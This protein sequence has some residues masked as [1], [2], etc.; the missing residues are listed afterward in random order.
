MQQNAYFFKATSPIDN[1]KWIVV[2][3]TTCSQSDSETH[4]INAKINPKNVVHAIT[5]HLRPVGCV[6]LAFLQ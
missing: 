2:R 3:N 4:R 6:A 1:V 5:A